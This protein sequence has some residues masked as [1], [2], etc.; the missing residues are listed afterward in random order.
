[1]LFEVDGHVPGAELAVGKSG[2]SLQVR[3]EARSAVPI[4]LLEIVANG[5]VVASR[6]E[7]KGAREI[8]LRDEIRT[9]APGWI[10]A[11]C[12]SRLATPGYRV[13]AHTSPVYLTAPGM[14][15]FSA[16]VAAYMLTLIDGAE[17]WAAHLATRPDPD[18]FQRVLQ[19]FKEAR[20]RLHERMH[21]HSA[22]A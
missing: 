2:G 18:Q 8:V 11:R 14:E 5:R 9:E 16:P 3:A 6:S 15:L 1:M 19:G 21:Q 4:H 12:S 10:A 20:R 17:T 22:S 7:D 13:A